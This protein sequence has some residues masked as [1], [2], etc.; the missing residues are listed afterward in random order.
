M[1][2]NVTSREAGQ[3]LGGSKPVSPRTL[4]SWRNNGTGPAFVR[5][6]PKT[7]R[8][9]IAALLDFLHSGTNRQGVAK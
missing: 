5:V 2:D 9:S 4:A 7:V 8:Y 3:I 1:S 6:G